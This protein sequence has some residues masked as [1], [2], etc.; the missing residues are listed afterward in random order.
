MIL[1]TRAAAVAGDEPADEAGVAAAA[2]Q[3]QPF[4]GGWQGG[5][6]KAGIGAVSLIRD[7]ERDGRC[8]TVQLRA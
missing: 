7:M 2:A 1:T 3:Q 8:G 5:K 4:F 6:L